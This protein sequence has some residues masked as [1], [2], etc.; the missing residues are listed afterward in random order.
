[1]LLGRHVAQIGDPNLGPCHVT[2]IFPGSALTKHL[3]GLV[4]AVA[5][6][7]F[8]GDGR[9]AFG[10][11]FCIGVTGLCQASAAL[12]PEGLF[13]EPQPRC[14]EH[15]CRDEATDQDLV[16]R[17]RV[18]ALKRLTNEFGN[19]FEPYKFARNQH[20]LSGVQHLAVFSRDDPPV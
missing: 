1:M 3:V 16:Q 18:T 20:P 7:M 19:S 10:V 5:A 12:V 11:L 14:V 8:H 2:M 17:P 15:V 4:I 6:E 9:P 13:Q